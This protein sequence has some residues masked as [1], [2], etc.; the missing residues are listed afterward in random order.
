MTKEVSQYRW[1]IPQSVT[2]EFR[3]TLRLLYG[4]FN[5]SQ[6]C[7]MTI[8]ACTAKQAEHQGD[9]SWAFIS[10]LQ[11][12]LTKMNSQVYFLKS[13][14]HL[15]F[16]LCPTNQPNYRSSSDFRIGAKSQLS[17]SSCDFV[18]NSATCSSN[19]QSDKEQTGRRKCIHEL[20][21]LKLGR[22]ILSHYILL[23]MILYAEL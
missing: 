9:A 23:P 2:L 12:E 15:P 11:T 18:A 22:I 3:R 8:L 19:C 13:L 10:C 7:S 21:N 1:R 17:R 5:G 4:H 6:G 20:V 16:A 14:F